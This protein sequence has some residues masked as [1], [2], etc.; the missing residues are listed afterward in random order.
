M[1][2]RALIR[3][4]ILFALLQGFAIATTET[5]STASSKLSHRQNSYEPPP[6]QLWLMSFRTS[7][8]RVRPPTDWKVRNTTIPSVGIMLPSSG[9]NVTVDTPEKVVIELPTTSAPLTITFTTVRV[10]KNVPLRSDRGL[11]LSHRKM[12]ALDRL[13][14]QQRSITELV[15]DASSYGP[16]LGRPSYHRFGSSG[17]SYYLG[18]YKEGNSFSTMQIITIRSNGKLRLLTAKIEGDATAFVE[19]QIDAWYIL[20]SIRLR[21]GMR[22]RCVFDDRTTCQERGT[23]TFPKS[24][25][26]NV[27]EMTSSAYV[28]PKGKPKTFQ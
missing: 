17:G 8:N 5:A 20:N 6:S 27:L 11:D 16:W 18:E 14:Q 28:K 26:K 10:P 4:G 25:P 3:F 12:N 23:K 21:D 1:R 7:L 22:Q 15:G 2:S 13:I 19:R 9:A 24:P